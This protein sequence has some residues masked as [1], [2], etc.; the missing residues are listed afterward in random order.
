MIDKKITALI[1]KAIRE[2]KYLSITYKNKS[3]EITLFWISITD[4]NANDELRV[5]MFNV[6][7][8]SPIIDGKIFISGIQSAEIL[9][10]SHYDVPEGLVK[11]LEHDESLHIYDFHRYDNN[12]LNYYLECHKANTDPFLHKAH[13]IQGL[14]LDELLKVSPCP[15]SDEQ[16]KQVIKDIYRNEYKPLNS[17]ELALCEFSIDLQS[18][19]KF[20]IAYR[21][22]TF[23]PVRKTLHL[24][25]KTHFNP[26][27]YIKGIKHSLSYY[28][29][30]SPADFEAMYLSNKAE[31]IEKLYGSFR[32]GELPN[33]RPELVVLGYS[34]IDLTKVYD[35]INADFSNKE[36]EKPLLAFFRTLSI[37][38]RKNRAEPHI[39]LYDRNINIDQLRTIYNALKYPVTYVQGPPGT[40]KTQTLVNIIVNCLINNKTLLISSNNN[41]PIDGIKDKLYLGK[42]KNKDILL[43]VIRLGNK[44]YVAQA[45]KTIKAL[46]DFETKEVPKEELLFK[47]KEQSK[48]SNKHLTAKLE[49]HEDRID[50]I[51]NLGFVNELLSKQ[52]NHLLEKE[53][54]ALE[55]KLAEKPA[56]VSDDLHSLYQVI[57]DNHKLLQF[58]YF[59][60]LRYIKRLS[61]YF[62]SG[63]LRY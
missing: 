24:G 57:K 3:G 54:Q 13:L 9:R 12:I 45:L 6:T 32:R 4:I 46:C 33:T 41:V 20:V 30:L 35:N 16:Q 8:E 59:E 63:D 37:L 14:D 17:Y 60:S 15:L 38:D 25:S 7:K 34:Q 48:E 27:F 11:R 19:G 1:G 61:V 26:N 40:G 58:F 62:P 28:T 44:A 10:F 53:K 55:K 52:K 2:E 42:Y 31:T 47:L 49:Q 43:P 22:L 36:V 39:V 5:N 21:K 51:Q 56:M 23:D 18:K 29:D 50:I